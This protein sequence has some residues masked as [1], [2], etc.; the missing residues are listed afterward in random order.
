MQNG[1]LSHPPPAPPPRVFTVAKPITAPRLAPTISSKCLSSA[2]CG[3][4]LAFPV[5]TSTLRVNA[6][7]G[8]LYLMHSDFQE[9]CPLDA[10]ARRVVVRQVRGKESELGTGALIWDVAILMAEMLVRTSLF[11]ARVRRIPEESAEAI[12]VQSVF[13]GKTV[14]ELGAGTGYTGLVAHTLGARLT[15]LTDVAAL[16]PTLRE[17][18]RLT[19]GKGKGSPNVR[20]EILE[21]SEDSTTA[22]LKRIE[23]EERQQTG[24]SVV[25]FAVDYVIVCECI[26]PR[27]YPIGPLVETLKAIADHSPKVKVL[28]GYEHRLYPYWDPRMVFTEMMRDVG[29]LRRSESFTETVMSELRQPEPKRPEDGPQVVP[30]EDMYLWE[31][32]RATEM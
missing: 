2:W 15:I 12:E 21:W 32:T 4:H 19:A 3:R 1:A 6:E 22:F 9:S 10:F 17:S 8:R 14:L 26:V 18:N 16:M 20:C 25:P 24:S 29:G 30:A 13:T 5:L 27:L 23:E 7:T 11:G 31:F 28:V